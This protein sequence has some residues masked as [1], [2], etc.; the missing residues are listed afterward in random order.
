MH[1]GA[2]LFLCFATFLAYAVSLHGTWAL[3]DGSIGQFASIKNSLDLRLGYRKVAQL[4]FVINKWMDPTDPLNYRVVNVIIHVF[5]S[6]LVYLVAFKTLSLPRWREKY[7]KHRY[8]VALLGSVVFA[9]HPINIDA[10]AYIVQRMTSLATMFVLL[11]VLSYLAARTAQ[12]GAMPK[13]LFYASTAVCILLGIFSK[14]NAV[15]AVPLLLLYDVMLVSVDN[16]RGVLK[17]TVAAA[18]VGAILLGTAAIFLHF[19]QA[20]GTILDL[21]LHPLRPVPPQYWTAI[22]VYW[23]PVQH[24]MTEFRVVS[25]YLFLLLLPLP[26]FLV[27]DWWGFPVSTGLLS[28]ASTLMSLF[29][30]AGLLAFSI[31]KRRKMPFLS[32]G[33]LWYF[34]AVSLESFL[35][36]GLDLYFEHRNYLP[37]TGLVIGVAAEAVSVLRRPLKG[38]TLWAAVC[39]LSLVLGGLTFQRNLVWKDSVTLWKDTVDKT[40]GN[41]RAMLA[42]GNSYLKVSD[43][44]TAKQYYEEAVKIS[45]SRKFARYFDDSV[46]SLGMTDLFMG[47]L[48]EVKKVIDIMDER[49]EGSYRSD[50]LKGAYSAMSGDP[51]GAIHRYEGILPSASGLDRAIVFNLMG[52]AFFRKGS[53]EKAI[54]NYNSAIATD[55]SF[56][57]AY[58]GLGTVYLSKKDLKNASFYIEKT[59]ALDPHNVL[60]LSDM[61]DI[62]LIKKEAPDKAMDL[63]AQAVAHSPV[64]YQPYLTMGNVLTV[65]G[66]DGEAEE[67]YRKAG[68]RGAQDYLIPFSRARAY[69]MKGDR[70]KAKVYLKKVLSSDDAPADLKK[71]ISGELSRM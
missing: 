43:L 29:L 22:D 49:T 63:A 60:A 4:S 18:V 28:P 20:A 51:D 61:A 66:R 23:S 44:V 27:F 13:I 67:Y 45:L 36:F 33:L 5:N 53:R 21:L 31:W 25:R 68:E 59:L 9:L 41:L 42:L 17:R 38:R 64:L 40:D 8:A 32:F 69:F 15:L 52:D 55:P 71:S 50:I 46:Y 14:E 57:A 58:Y 10:V 39:V 62:L 47:K 2:F 12:G 37:L 3:D 6:F 70:A 26:K 7:G 19:G 35:V 24:M 11:A 56:A 1:L 65:I 30:V 48:E 16:N 34:L 54:E